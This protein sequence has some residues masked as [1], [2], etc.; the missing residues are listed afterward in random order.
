[1]SA[2]N[3]TP[4]IGCR[5]EENR[6]SAI[7]NRQCSVRRGFTLVEVMMVT[8]LA[9][10][11][12]SA[13]AA[14]MSHAFRLWNDAYARWRLA[15]VAR[16]TR[17]IFLDGARNTE[18]MDGTMHKGTGFLSA[19]QVVGVMPTGT[20]QSGHVY[21]GALWYHYPALNRTN[22]MCLMWIGDAVA[23]GSYVTGEDGEVLVNPFYKHIAFKNVNRYDTNGVVIAHNFY[24]DMKQDSLDTNRVDGTPLWFADFSVRDLGGGAGGLAPTNLYVR[25]FTPLAEE[26]VDDWNKADKL[27]FLSLSYELVLLSGGKQY[28]HPEHIWTRFINVHY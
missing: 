22:E 17:V 6:Q 14:A 23:E 15:E 18:D 3:R 25:R 2:E 26:K 16:R 13:M 21:S 10:L 8:L 27:Y 7:G 19:D 28:T 1:M 9:F 24:A 4:K 5:R 20:N 12:F 11:V